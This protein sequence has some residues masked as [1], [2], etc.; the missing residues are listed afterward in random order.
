M[1]VCVCVCVCVCV[2]CACMYTYAHTHS[3]I[4]LL[5]HMYFC[6]HTNKKNI[7][8]T[9]I[10]TNNHAHIY[11]IYAL[12]LSLHSLA[13]A[14][15][16]AVPSSRPPLPLPAY[17]HPSLFTSCALSSA[18][19]PPLSLSVSFHSFS[20]SPP[21]RFMPQGCM[22]NSRRLGVLQQPALLALH[23][24]KAAAP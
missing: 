6:I 20:L 11:T 1:H 15:V 22:R 7:K 12:A 19:F 2:S 3:H 18:L 21:H 17:T 14:H 16:H 13:C 4:L 8:H 10:I 23:S 9:R 5:A 24:L